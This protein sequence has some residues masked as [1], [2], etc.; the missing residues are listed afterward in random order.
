MDSILSDPSKFAVL[1]S[2][3]FRYDRNT[4]LA[5]DFTFNTINLTLEMIRQGYDRRRLI[6]QIVKYGPQWQQTSKDKG[7]WR[8][9][10]SDI[11]STITARL[12]ADRTNTQH[13]RTPQV[14]D[15]AHRP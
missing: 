1:R 10:M 11:L 2:Q 4:T 15:T 3:M 9:I 14:P 12:A 13:H 7:Q 5:S 6:K 8:V